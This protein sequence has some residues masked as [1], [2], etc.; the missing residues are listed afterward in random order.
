MVML[1]K[2]ISTSNKRYQKDQINNLKERT[3]IMAG[4]SRH[5]W[6]QHLSL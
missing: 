1:S 6:G 2:H 4:Y 3:T 5:L